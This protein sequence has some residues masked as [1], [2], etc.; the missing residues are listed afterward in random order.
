MTHTWRDI[1]ILNVRRK[2]KRF[3]FL[4]TLFNDVS[5]TDYIAPITN[6]HKLLVGL[7]WQGNIVLRETSVSQCHFLATDLDCGQRSISARRSEK[8]ANGGSQT[9]HELS[10][11]VV[12]YFTLCWRFYL[13]VLIL[14]YLQYR[15]ASCWHS[16]YS[17]VYFSSISGMCYFLSYII[18]CFSHFFFLSTAMFFPVLLHVKPRSRKMC[19]YSWNASLAL[20]LELVYSRNKFDL[21]IKN[22][23]SKRGTLHIIEL[24]CWLILFSLT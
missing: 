1:V 6:E 5:R 4:N 9:W 21:V 24:C 11:S 10:C 16:L 15:T 22:M 12:I 18:Q 2:T 20:E 19:I 3:G 23:F 8:P 14:Y 17:L 7:Y 13:S